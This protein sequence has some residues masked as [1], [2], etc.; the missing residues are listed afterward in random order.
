MSKLQELLD[1]RWPLDT[2]MSECDQDHMIYARKLFEAGYNAAMEE[3]CGPKE[4]EAIE[5]PSCYGTG[6]W[7]AEC[8]NGSGGCSCGGQPVNMG[9]CNV[10]GGSGRVE[11]GAFNSMANV[12][13]IERGNYGYLG[14]GPKWNTNIRALGRK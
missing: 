9:R 8:C 7:E 1:E 3:M 5:C 6:E 14:S 11:K 10:C 2:T 13:F 12:D 4:P